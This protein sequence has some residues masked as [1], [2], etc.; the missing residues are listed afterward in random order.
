MRAAAAAVDVAAP[1]PSG[2]APLTSFATLCF[3]HL[4]QVAGTTAVVGIEGVFAAGDV[5]DSRYRQA[6]TSAG[7]GAMAALDA[8]RF[9]SEQGEV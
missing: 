2:T 3:P 7:T 8:E 6:V 4:T 1:V 9:L 5:Q